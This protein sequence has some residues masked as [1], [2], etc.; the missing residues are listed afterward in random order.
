VR[1]VP[2]VPYE[3]FGHFFVGH[4]RFVSDQPQRRVI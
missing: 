2:V 4:V 1:E 3:L